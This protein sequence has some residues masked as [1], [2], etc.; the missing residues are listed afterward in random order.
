M[1][2]EF[3]GR[4]SIISS[5]APPIS[6]NAAGGSH[7]NVRHTG[8]LVTFTQKHLDSLAPCYILM[9]L[10]INHRRRLTPGA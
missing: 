3:D 1:L 9:K 2:Y 7:V 5:S 4:I 8:K 10:K 6:I